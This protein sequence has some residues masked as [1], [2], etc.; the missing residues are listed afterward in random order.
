MSIGGRGMGGGFERGAGAQDPPRLVEGT[1]DDVPA[2]QAWAV[3][4]LRRTPAHRTPVGRKQRVRV[5]LARVQKRRAALMLRP[6]IAMAVL[7]GFAAVASAALGG[8]PTLVSKA[9]RRL[10]GAPTPTASDPRRAIPPGSARAGGPPAVAPARSPAPEDA[11]PAPARLAEAPP[12][13]V[14]LASPPARVVRRAPISE[15]VRG[16]TR[17]S[18]REPAGAARA[19]HLAAPPAG[20]GDDTAPVI[21]A[22]RALRVE[23]NPARARALLDRYL[24]RFPRGTLA[25]EALAMS[26]EAANVHHDGDAGALARRYLKLYPAGHF[27]ALAR[28]TLNGASAPAGN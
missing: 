4:L 26:I 3:D 15:S 9:Y 7:I 22:M 27:S 20:T 5:G 28:Q 17:G 11:V 19:R 23:G 24:E 16:L 8:W 2:A 18:A 14:Q 13:V 1:G 10:L 21:Q 12:V 25:E 6:A